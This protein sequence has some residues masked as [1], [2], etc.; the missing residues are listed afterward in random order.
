MHFHAVTSRGLK[1]R[2]YTLESL[3]V[4]TDRQEDSVM[5]SRKERPLYS[6]MVGLIE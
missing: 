2:G 1:R 6:I 4:S 5:H 3:P